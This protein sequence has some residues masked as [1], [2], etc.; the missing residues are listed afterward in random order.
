MACCSPVGVGAL[1]ECIS[2]LACCERAIVSTLDASAG[3]AMSREGVGVG[4]LV[5][6]SRPVESAS[7]VDSG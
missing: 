2:C 7:P 5:W 1:P 4:S 6:Y 3:V